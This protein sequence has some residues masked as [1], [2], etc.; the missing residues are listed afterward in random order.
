M[1]KRCV[2]T[3]LLQ[4]GSPLLAVVLLLN[5]LRAF[6][7]QMPIFNDASA[8]PVNADVKLPEWDVAS[9][10]ENKGDDHM[11]RIMTKPDGFSSTNV[12]LLTL[13]GYAYGIKQDLISGGPGW[14]DSKG[15]DVDAKVAG[16]DVEQLKKLTPL[17]RGS[18]LQSLLADR[19]KLKIHS[20]TKTLPIYEL[21][22]M[23]GGPKFKEAA[24]EPPAGDERKDN[25][26]GKHGG[27]TRMG[28]GEFT[29]QEIPIAS[30]AGI[31]CYVVHRTVLDKT[32]LT[33]KYDIALRYAA[34]DGPQKDDGAAETS[35]PSIFTALQEQL[36]LKLV[37]TKGPVETLVID[38]V[39]L[40]SEN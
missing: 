31:L 27:M 14:I 35:S 10:R 2:A 30:L 1:S 21:T 19:F 3:N 33:G 4:A 25:N 26:P 23:K 36:G 8:K 9:V 13:I 32:G 40:P 34:E 12:S 16:P 20:E 24:P 5:G 18:M 28:P 37:S 7:Q 17:Q 38:H 6:P 39:E 11:M 29:G 15:F 22:L